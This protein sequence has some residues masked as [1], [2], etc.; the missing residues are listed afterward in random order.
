MKFYSFVFCLFLGN[1]VFAQ[2]SEDLIPKDAVTVFSINNISLLQKI[3]MDDLVRYEFMEEVQQELFDGSTS[4]KTLKDSGIDFNQKLNVFYGRGDAYEV[5][6]FTFG[7]KN[8]EE[9]FQ[10]F[11]DFEKIESTYPN[12]EFYSSYFNNLI[13]RGNSALLIRVEPTMEKVD[14]VTDSIW[15]AR[16]NEDPWTMY[17]YEEEMESDSAYQEILEEEIFEEMA[18]EDKPVSSYDFPDA[19]ED[20]N[21]KNYYE[22]RDSVQV[23]MQMGF[24]KTLCDELLVKKIS[25]ADFDPRFAK[26]LTH[27]SEGIFYLDNSRNLEK[28]KGLW[29]FQT[30]FPSLYDDLK[31]LYSENIL[32]GDLVLKENSVEFL[33][34][35]HYGEELGSIYEK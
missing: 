4:G 18:E 6:G 17:D 2:Q 29:Y 12:V 26:Q 8:K 20:P 34:E 27:A 13:I 33:M 5:S 28:A 9:L 31:N 14:E 23:Q 22:L 24:L 3:S 16:G 30:M 25:L 21:Q 1:L 7:I 19:D 10:V 32:L 15:Y 11:D 35:A